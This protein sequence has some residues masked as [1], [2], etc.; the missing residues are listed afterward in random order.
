MSKGTRPA[1]L[2]AAAIGAFAGALL[3]PAA[4]GQDPDVMTAVAD[5]VVQRMEKLQALDDI[6]ESMA[7][8]WDS[9]RA[10]EGDLRR[11]RTEEEKTAV[12]ETLAELH[13]RLAGLEE[14]FELTATGIDFLLF[15]DVQQEELDWRAEI[16]A[17]FAPMLAEMRSAAAYP[18]EVERLRGEIALY[19]QR[20]PEIE[21]AVEQLGE[22]AEETETAAVRSRLQTLADYWQQRLAEQTAQ[23][24]ASALQL[25]EMLSKRT[26]LGQAVGGIIEVFFRQRG[27]NLILAVLAFAG[28]FF[29]LRW[30]QGYVQRA[31]PLLGLSRR[32]FLSRLVDVVYYLF[33]V[34]AAVG[35]LLTVLYLSGDWVLLAIAVLFLLGLVWA[36]K[37]T[38]PAF[39]DN[40]RLLLNLGPVREGER[41]VYQ[42]VA[43]RVAAL[44]IFSDLENPEL[45]GGHFRLPL[46]DLTTLRSRPYDPEREPLFPTRLHDWVILAD[47]FYG[48][49]IRQTPEE[50]VIA[51]GRG[52]EK[53]YRT[54]DF[55]AQRPKNLSIATFAVNQPLNLAYRH[56]DEALD[57]IPP[58]VRAVVE[59]FVGR[60]PYADC[61]EQ[62]VVELK[63]LGESALTFNVIA[64]FSGGAAS[65]YTEIGWLL[66]QAGLE[67]CRRHG[68]EIPYPQLVVNQPAGTSG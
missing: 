32:H 26:G 12:E 5:E 51:T 13:N 14:D 50:V 37:N 24:D 58:K 6:E 21:Q 46:R 49:V 19:D 63:E 25:E 62:V 27:R 39:L 4:V 22:L 8:V 36:L 7:Q 31:T 66:A 56:A 33:T 9:V 65:E 45:E 2:R 16:E 67:A 35:A 68:W 57:G 53:T 28:I 38:I 52:S 54:A 59:E 44:N 1:L 41:V 23:R 15:E 18:R 30:L 55:L 17:I 64:K 48:R 47:G 11:A 42:G 40:A 60:Q 29:L 43:W 3:A 61:L 34:I 20:L 10:A